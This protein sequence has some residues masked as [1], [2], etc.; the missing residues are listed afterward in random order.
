MINQSE[1]IAANNSSYHGMFYHLQLG[2]IILLQAFSLHCVRKLSKFEITMENKE[3]GKF[4]DI[5]LYYEN[6]MVNGAVEQNEPL[7]SSS[8]TAT[9]SQYND[10]EDSSSKQGMF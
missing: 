5:V 9:S 8:K 6:A 4:D 10:D 2:V 1:N 7:P 3:G